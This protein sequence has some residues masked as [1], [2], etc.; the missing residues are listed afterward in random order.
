MLRYKNIKSKIIHISS[1]KLI[2]LL[3]KSFSQWECVRVEQY[4]NLP[5]KYGEELEKWVPPCYLLPTELIN[6]NN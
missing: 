2:G 5:T 6:G 4:L 1:I 3:D